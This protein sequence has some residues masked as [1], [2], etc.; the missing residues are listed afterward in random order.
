M[1]KGKPSPQQ[2]SSRKVRA[3]S[4]DTSVIEA[5]SFAFDRGGFRLLAA[6][7][8]PWM[9]LWISSVVHRE[10]QAHR[11]GSVDRSLEEIKSGIDSLRRHAGAAIKDVPL[12]WL[13]EARQ[14]ARAE[15]AKQFDKFMGSYQ[16]S[17][18]SFD[19]ASQME[20]MFDRYFS[21][22]PPFGGGKDKKHEFPDA[23][24]LLSLEWTAKQRD[25]SVIVVSKDKG[26]Q[27]FSEQSECLYFVETLEE[28]ASF[29]TTN[30][31]RARALQQD[32]AARLEDRNSQFTKAVVS[33]VRASFDSIV[34]EVVPLR[35]DSHD[36]ELRVL[37]VVLGEVDVVPDVVGVW[38][39]AQDERTAVVE[40]GIQVEAVVH[41]SAVATSMWYSFRDRSAVSSF[42]LPQSVEL[43]LAVELRG[44]IGTAD[45][46]DLIAGSEIRSEPISVR[47]QSIDFG[48]EVGVL[49]KP[50]G[51]SA[52][53]D[54]MN[55][56]IPF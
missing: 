21:G 2:L 14:A 48:G 24:A 22:R 42:D 55:D 12:G 9:E 36:V 1:P 31:T 54:D 23:A 5:A 45:P 49:P 10:V 56:D 43:R 39:T 11:M 15:F 4:I 16:G 20:Q 53:F 8:P 32:I 7:L 44:E 47:I 26:W 35:C 3:F 13:P 34:W 25:C 38:M 37:D 6:Q 52:G 18:I 41:I 28:L 40:I 29:Y 17:L 46:A 30:S 19:D 51:G 50:R 27:A 33:N